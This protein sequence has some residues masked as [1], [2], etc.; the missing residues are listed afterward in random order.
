M[1]VD[2]AD[3]VGNLNAV[4]GVQ[5]GDAPALV[6]VGELMDIVDE[7]AFESGAAGVAGQAEALVIAPGNGE[8]AVET[9]GAVGTCTEPE[10]PATAV[11][12]SGS[13]AQAAVMVARAAESSCCP[14][15]RQDVDA[16]ATKMADSDAAL[17]NQRMEEFIHEAANVDGPTKD[18]SAQTEW[19]RALTRSKRKL[20]VTTPGI[21]PLTKKSVNRKAATD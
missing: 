17:G 18:L 13:D 2:T 20:L 14:A 16:V 1:S 19:K 5:Q 8:T 11:T 15:V 12:C 6:E 4:T 3:P 10:A 9:A 21:S 7:E